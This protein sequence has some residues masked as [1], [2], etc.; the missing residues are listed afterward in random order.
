M[1]LIKTENVW[2]EYVLGKVKLTVLKDV[3]LSIAV[4]PPFQFA[5]LEWKFVSV[6]VSGQNV[7]PLIASWGT[8]QDQES[9]QTLR[10]LNPTLAER[11]KEVHNYVKSKGFGTSF[12]LLLDFSQPIVKELY[13]ESFTKTER[14]SVYQIT[15][16]TLV[17][18]SVSED[19]IYDTDLTFTRK[20]IYG[21]VQVGDVVYGEPIVFGIGFTPSAK[22][23]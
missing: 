22:D 13:K 12:T 10:P 20:M 16:K 14:P 4:D 19:F 3:S 11:A 6:P 23:V 1:E 18:D 17:Y 7:I 21:E 15:Q 2:K 5:E 9:F 8:T